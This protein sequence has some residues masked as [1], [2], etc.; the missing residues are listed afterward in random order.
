MYDGL[1]AAFATDTNGRE[2]T[3]SFIRSPG[4][5]SAKWVCI[6]DYNAFAL[7]STANNQ[8]IIVNKSN[9]SISGSGNWNTASI[10]TGTIIN[11]TRNGNVFTIG[12]N[13]LNQFFN[14]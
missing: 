13:I 10:G 1:V 8:A 11:M 12:S 7:T 6:M 5:T 2:H 14:N 3:L 9:T 4:G